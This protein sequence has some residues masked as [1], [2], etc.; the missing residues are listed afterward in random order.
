MCGAR[1]APRPWITASGI[2]ARIARSS[3]SRSA[4]EPRA[5]ALALGDRELGGAREADGAW[6]RS[7][8]PAGAR[9][10]A[11]RRRQ[12]RLDRR[13]AADVQRADALRR[14]DLV[15]GDGEE[16]ERACFARRCR[17]LPNA[18]TASVWNSAPRAF[19]R[20]A[21]SS[22]IGCTTPISL[23]THITEHDARRRR[24][25]ARRTT[26][27]TSTTPA[28][29]HRERAAP[30][31]PRCATWCTA[32]S[33]A[34]CSIGVVT[35]AGAPVGAPSSP[36]AEDREVVRLGAAGGEADLVRSGAEAARDALARLVERGARLAPPPMRRST[37]CRSAGRR[38]ASIASST[39]ARTGVVAAWSR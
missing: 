20:V 37:G 10:P 19:A 11:S 33:T 39:S 28:A 4:L 24:V 5:L 12:Q 32:A 25:R 7:P 21:T 1:G 16:V 35:T 30:R 2:V 3:R 36:A 31:R 8:C 17:T 15:P 29:R 18:C 38:T 9:D 34:L 14:A 26:S 27:S 22:A 23:F 13:A 6:R